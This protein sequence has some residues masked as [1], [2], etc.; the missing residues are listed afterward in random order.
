MRAEQK[1]VVIDCERMK[2]PYTG[3]YHFC[4]QLSQ[5]LIKVNRNQSLCFYTPPAVGKIFGEEQ[6]YLLQRNPHKL[7]FPPTRNMALWHCTH[8]D[9]DYFPFSRKLKKVLTIHDL[10]YLHDQRKTEEKKKRF[11]ENVQRKI[12]EADHLVFISDF[13]FNDARS[14]LDIG[15]EKTS[16][17]YNGC[18]IKELSLLTPPPFVPDKPFLLTLGTITEKKNLHVLPRLLPGND[19]LLLIAGITQSE[20]YKEKIEQEAKQL[21]VLD[22]VIFTGPVGEND[23]QWYLKHCTAF[24]FPSLAEGFGLPV[25]EAMYFEKPVLLSTATSLPEIG[26]DVADYFPGF[27]VEEMQAT[28]QKSLHEWESDP[29]R[30]EALRRRAL[31]F[32]WDE[33]AERYLAIYQKLLTAC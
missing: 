30:K 6:C 10:N 11:K 29:S 33:A 1:K 12:D 23:K 27:A 13:S 7:I 14:N 18:T 32:S 31:S 17:I 3:L 21:G 16:V 9:S 19:F 15:G 8:Q 28:L 2:Y 26:G 24:V 4:L 22:R 25:L 20:A 5:S